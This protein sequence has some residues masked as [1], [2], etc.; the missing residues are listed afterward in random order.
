MLWAQQYIILETKTSLNYYA[1]G[2]CIIN[3]LKLYNQ[4]FYSTVPQ[5]E[6]I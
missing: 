1:L 3:I 4:Q 2:M 6:K 5:V